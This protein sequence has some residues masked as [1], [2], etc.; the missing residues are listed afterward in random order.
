MR[1]C[2]QY[3]DAGRKIKASL[4]LR[5]VAAFQ[6]GRPVQKDVAVAGGCFR[7]LIDGDDDRLHMLI[8]SQPSRVARRRVASSACKT[9]TCCQVSGKTKTA[10]LPAPFLV[11]Q[12]I[13][14]MNPDLR[15][16]IF[17]QAFAQLSVPPPRYPSERKSSGRC[18]L[19]PACIRTRIANR[20]ASLATG[21]RRINVF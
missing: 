21:A 10:P 7:I 13:M 2:T 3:G 11:H 1:S 5:H 15:S 20:V 8:A 9:S 18:A 4:R 19:P 17:P 16:P 6:T 14:S 12:W